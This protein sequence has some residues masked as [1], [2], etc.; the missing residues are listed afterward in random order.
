MQ[1]QLPSSVCSLRRN[2]SQTYRKQTD[3]DDND[4][5]EKSKKWKILFSMA[6]FFPV[7][8]AKQKP[9]TS[10]DNEDL[11]EKLEKSKPREK[12]NFIADVV[13]VII[14]S[15]VQIGIKTATPYGQM[16]AASGSGF[17]VTTDGVI[18]TNAHVVRNHIRD[19]NVKLNDGRSF[20]GRVL[21]IDRSADL[22]IIKIDCV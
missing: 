20:N 7:I 13:E 16:D 5:D 14:P 15:I 10:S 11:K 2:L 19:I 21:K 8:Y 6:L 4:D 1:Y 12:Y 3:N 22:A 9:T 18:L 17:I